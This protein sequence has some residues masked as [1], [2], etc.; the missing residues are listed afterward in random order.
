[1]SLSFLSSFFLYTTVLALATF[2]G[3]LG[4]LLPPNVAETLAGASL[5]LV[6][7]LK[8]FVS[9]IVL[10]SKDPFANGLLSF[11]D[12]TGFGL[13]SFGDITGGLVS[14]LGGL[15]SGLGEGGGLLSNIGEFTDLS[16]VARGSE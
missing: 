12:I 9:V 4:S 2:A 13:L 7:N 3:W 14:N 10:F 1:V 6:D 15:F 5:I 11:G 16:M 8:V